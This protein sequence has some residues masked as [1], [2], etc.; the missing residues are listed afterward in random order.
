M[1]EMT[2]KSFERAMAERKKERAEQAVS[3]IEFKA[4][5]TEQIRTHITPLFQAHGFKNGLLF[6]AALD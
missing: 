5:V 1:D 2:R 3:D 6:K 4:W